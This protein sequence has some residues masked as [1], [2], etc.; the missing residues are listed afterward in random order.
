[1][2]R[3]VLTLP[4]LA[5]LSLT[6]CQQ[7]SPV[8]TA[9]TAPVVNTNIAAPASFSA[10]ASGMSIP[11]FREIS[12]GELTRRGIGRHSFG[13][14]TSV[15]WVPTCSN[16]LGGPALRPAAL[17]GGGNNLPIVLSLLCDT[18]SSSFGNPHRI[19]TVFVGE[20][21]YNGHLLA[22]VERGGQLHRLLIRESDLSVVAR[23]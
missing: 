22:I 13:D 12:R 14:V 10:A 4:L 9:W 2:R 21:E 3:F 5:A 17:Q 18:G 7:E 11:G 16:V 23:A 20:G 6:A 1:M 8:A 15:L 19:N